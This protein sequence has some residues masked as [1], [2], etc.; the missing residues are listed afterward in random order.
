MCV[1]ERSI[2]KD[3]EKETVLKS[4]ERI[5]C[6]EELQITPSST[7]RNR[8]IYDELV[9]RKMNY[10]WMDNTKAVLARLSLFRFQIRPKE[11]EQKASITL[12]SK[13]WNNSSSNRSIC[14]PMNDL[15]ECVVVHI[16]S[17]IQYSIIIIYKYI[18][19]N[20]RYR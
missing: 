1:T 14:I 13:R 20:E 9:D 18:R 4:A 6:R 19:G 16:Y 17:L 7:S 5:W 8:E 2:S 11:K 10:F 3:S 15:F 12:E